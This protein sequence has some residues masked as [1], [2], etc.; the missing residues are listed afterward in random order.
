MPLN[1]TSREKEPGVFV[2]SSE[3]SLDTNTFSIL[4]KQ[5]DSILEGVPKLIIFDME[6][7]N[8]ISSMGIRVVLKA[9]KALEN[10]GGSIVLLNLKP[11]IRKVF[12]IINALP[13]EQVFSSVEEMDRYLD[14]MQRKATE[15]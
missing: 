5:V 6:Y 3:G 4:E 14:R 1:V 9:R 15:D 12:D 7:L 2:L 10:R 8:Y 13:S 11:H